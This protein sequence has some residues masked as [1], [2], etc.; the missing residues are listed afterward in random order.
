MINI[1]RSDGVALW[2]KKRKLASTGLSTVGLV[3]ELGNVL[4]SLGKILTTYSPIRGSKNL[5]IMVV[6]SK[7]CMMY[8]ASCGLVERH[9]AYNI[10]HMQRKKILIVMLYK[11]RQTGLL[12]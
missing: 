8:Q 7:D 6:Q 12:H 9:L 5:L 10:E 1:D 11:T 4:L 2:V 3:L